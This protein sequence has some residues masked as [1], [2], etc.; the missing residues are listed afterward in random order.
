MQV[1]KSPDILGK[2][3]KRAW[4]RKKIFFFDKLGNE[5][6]LKKE[7]K[8]HLEK[9]VN[10]ILNCVLFGLDSGIR[11]DERCVLSPWVF[12]AHWRAPPSNS[13]IQLH[14]HGVQFFAYGYPWLT[15]L[16]KI[17]HTALS[18]SLP[19]D[20]D[21]T[22]LFVTIS[23]HEIDR[24]V[25]RMIFLDATYCPSRKGFMWENWVSGVCNL[26]PQLQFSSLASGE[27]IGPWG[28][29]WSWIEEDLTRS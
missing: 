1:E 24:Y 29:D 26:I 14:V 27:S 13:G 17:N 6:N 23:G 12:N 7:I 10:V 9:M 20:L 16:P 8:N 3:Y 22:M 28:D 21:K 11:L 15:I 5:K 2:K 25:N 18:T 4:Q 19:Y